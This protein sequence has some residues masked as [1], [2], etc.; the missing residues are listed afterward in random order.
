[1]EWNGVEWGEVQSYLV[2]FR[3]YSWAGLGGAIW[4]ARDGSPHARPASY[5]LFYSSQPFISREVDIYCMTVDKSGS[6]HCPGSPF[7]SELTHG[8][9][10]LSPI[11]TL[12]PDPG[13]TAL[14][15]SQAVCL[16]C[17]T[18]WSLLSI[19]LCPLYT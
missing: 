7:F 11:Y 8:A 19:V 13:D 17:G 15:L 16:H 2:M 10:P 5:L 12:I 18:A 14:G 4:D 9:L 6:F 3:D 1:M